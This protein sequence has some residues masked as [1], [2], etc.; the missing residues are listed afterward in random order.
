MTT[1]GL[2]REIHPPAGSLGLTGN[3]ANQG[4]QAAGQAFPPWLPA[5]F[6]AFLHSHLSLVEVHIIANSWSLIELSRGHF[7]Y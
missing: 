7:A 2:V 4:L 3:Q 1:G 6:Q 5:A